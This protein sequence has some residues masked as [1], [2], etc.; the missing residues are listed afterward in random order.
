MA[1]SQ[2]T[3]T[4]V[5]PPQYW[6]AQVYLSWQTTSPGGT[7]F[8]IYLDQALSWFGQ[9]TSVRLPVP[10]SGVT[11][12]DIGTVLPGE[13]QTD[14]SS[15]LPAAPGRKAELSWLG[16]TFEAADIAGFR[17]F[18]SDSAGGS[19]D[20]SAVL[21][22]ITA[23][24]SGIYT[25]GWGL[26]GWGYGGW[27]EAASTYSWTS[28][29]LTAGTWFYAVTPYDSAGN[30]GTAAT[31]SIDIVAPPLAPAPFADGLRLTYTFNASL[32][33]ATLLWNASPG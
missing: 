21:A 6:G 25:D 3:I 15:S 11:R 23:Y 28:D 9:S 33:E 12:V 17:V 27:G 10:P 16:G 30:L 19:V 18:G 32:E 26:G 29:S 31:V 22:D 14:F 7:W 24:P 4:A 20:Y 13:E 5:N 8:Q 1:F 2:A